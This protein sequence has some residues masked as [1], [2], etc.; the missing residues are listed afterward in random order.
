MREKVLTALKLVIDPEVQIN[1]IDMGLVYHV[2][3]DEKE[4]KITITMTLSSPHCPMG[5]TIVTA[6]Q[7]CLEFHF[8]AYIGEVNLVWEPAWTIDKI[9]EE[10]KRQLEA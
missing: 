3:I 10:G 4:K 7:N 6:V 1:I 9:S 8:E 2:N 5:N